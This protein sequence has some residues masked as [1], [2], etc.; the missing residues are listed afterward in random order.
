MS[1]HV[2]VL[3]TTATA[4]N[5]VLR[6]R[7]VE[8]GSGKGLFLCRY[9]KMYPEH[10]IIGLELAKKYAEMSHAKLTKMGHQHACCL[11]VDACRWM[12]EQNPDSFDEVHVYFPD[13][14]WKKRHKKRRVLNEGMV[15][16]IERTLKPGG[17]LHFW[18]DVL[19][20]FESTLELL[21]EHTKLIGPEFVPE[22]PPEN[23]MDYRTHFERR[24]RLNQL[25][26]YRSLF[27]KA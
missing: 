24:T 22:T 6:K 7:I 21:A 10:E 25:P 23:D 16:N 4:D 14:W 3:P 5:G 15:K 18:T 13:P 27:R 26:V 9:A 8:V 20:Y 19:E 17:E 2:E 12:A 11:A 1:D